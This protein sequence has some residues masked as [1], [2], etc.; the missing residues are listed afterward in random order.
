MLRDA[1]IALVCGIA[2]VAEEI[3]QACASDSLDQKR[4][5]MPGSTVI[6]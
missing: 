6:D 5:Q 1:N 2:G 4:F 3:I